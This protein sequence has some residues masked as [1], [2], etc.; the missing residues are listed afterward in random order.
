[1]PKLVALRLWNAKVVSECDDVVDRHVG[2]EDG[3]LMPVLDN[4]GDQMLPHGGRGRLK[5]AAAN[6]PVMEGF[7]HRAKARGKTIAIF[8]ARFE[9]FLA[10]RRGIPGV[11]KWK[12]DG[13]R[14]IPANTTR[15]VAR[16]R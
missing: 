5:I 10:I 13:V 11:V 14:K 9:A 7:K 1:M 8:D 16:F 6:A 4:P 12:G 15:R 2:I 3:A